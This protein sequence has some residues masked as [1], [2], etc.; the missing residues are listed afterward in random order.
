MPISKEEEIE[1][2]KSKDESVETKL[3]NSLSLIIKDATSFEN[4]KDTFEY[5]KGLETFI[6]AL[7]RLTHFF[8]KMNKIGE[9]FKESLKEAESKEDKLE[10]TEFAIH[11]ALKAYGDFITELN[12]QREEEL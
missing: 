12:K 5:L 4:E 2:E 7:N 8:G 11:S 6:K 3:M 10:K 9:R 1:Y